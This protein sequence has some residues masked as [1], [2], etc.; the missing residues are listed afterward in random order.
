LD[1]TL[2]SVNWQARHFSDSVL[3]AYVVGALRA[4]GHLQYWRREDG[5]AER[6]GFSVHRAWDGGVNIMHVADKHADAARHEAIATYARTLQ[7]AGIPHRITT[8][9]RHYPVVYVP[10][11]ATFTVGSLR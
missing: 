2:P 8:T 5:L 9:G 7:R 10:A 1:T 4:A 6:D 3:H 11:W